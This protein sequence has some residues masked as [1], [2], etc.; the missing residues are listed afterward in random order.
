MTR[1]ALFNIFCPLQYSVGALA[2]DQWTY[3]LGLADF[4]FDSWSAL[5][6]NAGL[7]LEKTLMSP[8]RCSAPLHLL[9]RQTCVRRRSLVFLEEN[10][11]MQCTHAAGVNLAKYIGFS[12]P[13]QPC[14]CWL[15][16][17]GK[18]YAVAFGLT[19][20]S[21]FGSQPGFAT[22]MNKKRNKKCATDKPP[23]LLL[24]A[25]RPCPRHVWTDPS[26]QV[27]AHRSHGALE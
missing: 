18:S 20:E 24:T 25:R 21:I 10:N 9:A 5:V 13:D 16:S 1:S 26:S 19:F 8:L 12:W 7:D 15:D 3:F 11:A 22:G 14:P 27:N 2:L 23:M 4:G 6:T 17:Q